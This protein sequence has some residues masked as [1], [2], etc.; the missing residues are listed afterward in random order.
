MAGRTKVGIVGFGAV[1][2]VHA[3]AY[4]ECDGVA[5]VSVADNDSAQLARAQRELGVPGYQSLAEMLR[6]NVPDI[7]CVLTPPTAHEELV[8]VAAEAGAHV[9]CEKPLSLTV[10]A[11][12]RM[13]KVCKT[14]NVRLCYGA[15]YRYLPAVATAREMILGG[16]I[17]EVL[18]LREYAVGGT[19]GS[20]RGTLGFGHYPKGGPGGS[21][22][23][24]FDHGIHLIDVFPWLIGSVVTAVSGRGNISG[25]PQRPEYANFEYANGAV[26]QLLYEDGTFTTT[27]PA[28]GVFAWGGGWNVGGATTTPSGSWNPDPGCIHVH[29]SKGSLRI[30][31]YANKLFHRS[32]AGVRQVKV[33][34]RPMPSNFGMQLNT[35]IEAIRSGAPTPVPGEVGLDALRTLLAI[36]EGN[37]VRLRRNTG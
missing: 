15:S 7:V 1:A 32:E 3:S 26:G 29:G 4:R 2:R 11:C 9:L 23:G 24:L 28:E 30:Y 33:P 36:Y 10:A 18:V 21:G 14:S 20:T 8:C 31:H 37:D 12:E 19:T 13:I 25:E 17:G 35:F 5:I 16:D 27:L 22:M 6:A 34:D